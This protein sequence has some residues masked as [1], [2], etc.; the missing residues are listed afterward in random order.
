MYGERSEIHGNRYGTRRTTHD[1]AQDVVFLR[2]RREVGESWSERN[3]VKG[4][5]DRG[6]KIHSVVVGVHV[7]GRRNK[8]FVW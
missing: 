5:D 1:L 4:D 2:P 7:V 3:C 8:C 6:R